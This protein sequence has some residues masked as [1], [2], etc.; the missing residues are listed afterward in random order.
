M[1]TRTQRLDLVKPDLNDNVDPVAQIADNMQK[2]DDGVALKNH[3]HT[4]GDDG[5]PIQAS[6]LAD[7]AAT[8]RVIGN[9]TLNQDLAS[10]ANSG[11]LTSLLSWL[12]GR[13]KAIMGTTNWYD[14]PAASLATL[15]AKFAPGSGHK[16]SGAAGDAPPIPLSGIDS[17]ARTS[18]GGAEANR[19]AV[20]D[21]SGAVGR[22]NAI[23]DANGEYRTAT[24]PGGWGS[25]AAYK[26]LI[27]DANGRAGDAQRLGGVDYTSY[28]QTS[29]AQAKADLA[30]EEGLVIEAAMPVENEEPEQVLTSKG[31]A[32]EF[33]KGVTQ[34]VQFCRRWPFSN[35]ALHM[36]LVLSA[37]AASSG[38]FH[39]RVGWQV[40]GGTKRNV[41]VSVAPGSHTNLYIANLGEVIPAA[42]LP[43]GALVTITLSRVGADSADTH[44]GALL[45][46]HCRLKRG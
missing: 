6:G 31:P 39:L 19:L 37:S 8:D 18:A 34:S 38:A 15:W 22:A 7:G 20:T 44:T 3:G 16:H 41:T 23:R 33:A 36:E 5:E 43:A 45:L 21:G 27:A 4:G 17:A 25:T 24:G 46:H 40:N 13:I 14:T 26:V 29:A 28:E 30:T 9:R 10:P 11:S 12:A 42:S 32:I 35:K 1:A 2:I